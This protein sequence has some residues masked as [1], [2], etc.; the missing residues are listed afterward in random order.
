MVKISSA[1]YYQIKN[2]ALVILKLFLLVTEAE[3]LSC[4]NML[5]RIL[6]INSLFLW[7]EIEVSGSYY[8]YKENILKKT[9]T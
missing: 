5:T 3:T 4:K 1:R 8:S 9:F 6:Y 2:N 7:H